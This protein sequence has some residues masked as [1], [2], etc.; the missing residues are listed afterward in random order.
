MSERGGSETWRR[1]TAGSLEQQLVAD[2]LLWTL[3]VV[4]RG[5]QDLMADG[6]TLSAATLSVRKPGLAGNPLEAFQDLPH[7]P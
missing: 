3:Q 7:P 2:V 6:R 1:N 5:P 4:L